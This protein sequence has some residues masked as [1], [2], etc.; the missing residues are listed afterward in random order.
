MKKK[1]A[2]VENLETMLAENERKLTQSEERFRAVVENSPDGIAIMTGNVHSF[3]NWKFLEIFGYEDKSEIVGKTLELVVHP[4]DLEKVSEH[5]INRQKE[6]TSKSFYIFRG[7][8]KSGE[9]IFVEV[10][11]TRI[12]YDGASASLVHLRDV[13]ERVEEKEKILHLA[14]HDRLTGLLNLN[15]FF[16]TSE[17]FLKLAIRNGKE[18]TLLFIDLD[19]MK[20]IN[21]TLGHS[22]GDRA[23][24]DTA[25]ILNH[26][27]R[28]SDIKARLG[29]DEF[30]I[31]AETTE[32]GN[33]L[34]E[35]LKKEIASFNRLFNR[36]YQVSFS[37]GIVKFD[38]RH[39]QT[40]DDLVSAADTLMYRNK[41]NKREKKIIED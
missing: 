27:F 33:T 34:E 12:I 41:R 11:A 4:D 15:G 31:L 9:V 25:K 14:N 6:K 35:R 1:N 30:V 38:P 17:Q 19:G 28:D 10:S 39:S 21:D 32:D 13:S 8:K 3:I 18:M 24:K 29:G 23:L 36:P 2:V 7:I 20:Q 5:N 16:A 26:C 37:V 22:D 40:I